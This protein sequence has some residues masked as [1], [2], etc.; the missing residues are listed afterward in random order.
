MK[1]LHEMNHLAKTGDD[2]CAIQ[3][4]IRK[5]IY[6]R[7][8]FNEIPDENETIA[9]ALDAAQIGDRGHRDFAHAAKTLGNVGVKLAFEKTIG[10]HVFQNHAATAAIGGEKASR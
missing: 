2:R 8:S 3:A 5:A 10:R 7:F 9:M 4:G 6:K 1:M